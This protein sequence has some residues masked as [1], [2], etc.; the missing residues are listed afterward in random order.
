MS[1]I[2]DNQ[3]YLDAVTE[4]EGKNRDKAL[5]A[6]CITLAEGDEEKAKYQYLKESVGK[7]KSKSADDKRAEINA[8]LEG[9]FF[10]TNL[11][12]GNYGLF[13]IYWIYYILVEFVLTLT[14][15]VTTEILGNDNF[16]QGV[17]IVAFVF[18]TYLVVYKRFAW[19]GIWRASN[20]YKGNELWTNLAKVA[21][22]LSVLTTIATTFFIVDKAHN[23]D[24]V[25]ILSILSVITLFILTKIYKSIKELK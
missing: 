14:L 2:D 17:A 25:I 22:V 11:K 23:I 8:T 5:W 16:K 3:F 24:A 7:F 18:F 13:K 1:K 6:K 10:I 15:F 9:K 20:R 4:F 19:V 12:E 21:V